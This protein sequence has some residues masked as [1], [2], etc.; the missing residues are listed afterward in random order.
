VPSNA[1]IVAVMS[2]TIDPT[3]LTSSSVTVTPSNGSAIAGT[4]TLASDGVTL[5]FVPSATL[6]SNK[7]YTVSVSGFSDAEGNTVTSFTSTFTAGSGNYGASSFKL[8]STSPANKATGIAVNSQVTFTMT[9]LIQAAS[10]NPQTVAVEICFDG[11]ACSASESVAG[12]YSVSGATITFTPLTPYPGSTVMGMEVNGL[13]D[14]AGNSAPDG[15]KYFT[16]A[17]TADTTPPTVTITPANGATNIGLN[18]Q[19]V[20]SFSESINA[21]TITSSSLAV[22]SGD[23]AVS[24]NFTISADNRTIILTPGGSAW[25]SGAVITVA[26]SNAIQDL[27]GNALVNTS[28]QFTLTTAASGTVPTVVSM[29]PG[30][31][32]TNVPANT[33]ITLFTSAAM[34]ASTIAG[35]LNVTDNGVVVSGSVQLFS[36]GQAIEFTPSSAFNPGDLIQVFLGST[37]LGANGAALSS[38]SGQFTVAGSLA[39]TAQV[40]AMNPFPNATS[41]PRNTNIQVEYNQA[42]LSS[43]VS[44]NGNSGSVT[45]FEVSSS[46]YLTP[47]CTVIGGGQVINIAPTGNLLSGSQY[48]VNVT[49]A[50]TNTSGTPVLAST[51]SFTAGT[52]VDNAAPTIV[53]Q[54]PTNNAT[55]IGTNARVAMNFNKAINPVSVTGSTIQLTGGSVTEVPSS[56]SFTPDYT[57]VM[58]VPQAPLPPS[59]A[60]TLAVNGVTSQAGINAATTSTSFTTAAQPD[61]TAP[62]VINS[63]VQNGQTNVPVNSVFSM[64]FSK[65][66]DIGSFNASNVYL[67]GGVANAIAPTTISWSSDQTTVS[68]VPT[69]PLNIGDNYSLCSS[70]MTDLD[71]NVQTSFCAS[72]TAAFTT[73]S[74]GPSVVNTSPENAQTQVP[75]NAPVQ[76]LFSEPVQPNTIG[77]ITLK[78]GGNPIAVSTSFSDA[79]QLLTLTPALPLLVNTSYTISITGVKDT[80]GNSM[81]GTVTNTF[82][83][84]GTFD[85]GAPSV[86]LTDPAADAL[87]VGTNV[88]ARVEFSKRM[89]PLSIATSSNEPYNQGSVELL[90]GDTGVPVPITVTMSSDRTTAILTPTSALLP[91]TL[92]QLSV[93]NAG[94]YYDVAGNSGSPYTSFF[95]T[96]ASTVASGTNVSSISPAN[97]QANVPLNTL[98]TVLMSGP[99]DP[100]SITNSSI[101]VT[102]SGASALAGTVSLASDGVTLTFTPASL[103]VRATTFNVSVS[104]FRDVQGNTVTTKTSTFTTNSATYGVNSFSVVSTNPANSTNNVPVN[105]PVTFTMTNLIDA[106]SV[107]AQTVQLVCSNSP[108][109]PCANATVAGTYSVTGNSV[110][111]TPLTPYPGGASMEMTLNGLMDVAGNVVNGG[112]VVAGSFSTVGT[113]DTTKPTVAITPSNGATNI[114]LNPQIVLTFSE[115]INPTT[116]GINSVAV[117]SGD[118]PLSPSITIS[119]DNRTVVLSG[120]TLPTSTKITVLANHLITDLSGN[121]LNDT[122]SQFTTAS[123]VLTSAPSVVNT[124]PANGAT[125]VATNTVIT[126]FTSA[127]M[128]VGTIPGAL[129]VSQNGV[130]V[131]G[132][133]TVAA[134]GQSI[135]FTPSSSFTAG[136]PIQV[137]L[138]STAQDTYGNNLTNFQATFTTAGSTSSSAVV[139]AVN[140]G[141][142]TS[143]VPLNTTIQVQYNQALQSG[144]VTCN[145]SSGSVTVKDS[146][147]TYLTPN[148]TLVGGGQVININPTGNLAAGTQYTVSVSASVTNTS[149]VPVSPFSYTFTAGAAVDNA[150]PVVISVTPPD[151]SIH[152]GTNAG[153]S[154]NFDRAINPVSVTGSSIQLSGGAVTAVPSSISFTPDYTRVTI[155]P[156]SPLPPNTQMAI[157]INGVTS[158]AGVPVAS[159]TTHFTTTAGPDL[160][161][162]FVIHASV[163]TNQFVGTNAAFAMQFNEP[164]DP[165]SVNPA[166]AQDVYLFDT[167]ASAAVP[168]TI[169]FSTDLTTVMLTPT[170]SLTPG[171]QMS[172]CSSAMTNLS[173]I[174]QQSFC[175]NFSVGA[176]PD[177]TGPSILQ[178]SP[179]AG[180]T[181]VGTNALIQILFNEQLDSASLAGVTL[182][183]GGSTIPT[184]TTLFDGNQG[185]QLLPLAPLASNT[186][187]TINVTGVLDITGNAQSSAPS[188]SF[189]TGSGLDLILPTVI[190][191]N[192]T[193]GATVPVTTTVQ[194]VFSEAMDPA[195]FDPNSSFTLQ[196]PSHNPVPAT[197]SFSPDY[198]TVTLTPNSALTNGV[199]YFMFASSL[200]P[201]Y[202]LAGNKCASKV[203]FFQTTP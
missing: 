188:Q 79:N 70:L 95:T 54:A 145:G 158:V 9:N 201:L 107:S 49:S 194:F 87:A 190:S 33:A 137:F 22:F 2:N 101:T 123:A 179:P 63:S 147:N 8:S 96:G 28:S 127:P 83:T 75:T 56:I 198:T 24:Y 3:T 197:I 161:S 128:N 165:G 65:P 67:S 182:K 103:L 199:S 164:I 58:I 86:L 157:A 149:S 191:T 16:T 139:Q 43:S 17:S 183:Q 119:A 19:I 13:L 72:F 84:G 166:G 15:F 143:N 66:M 94:N 80:A 34:N 177:T 203:L 196:D 98:V 31:G 110:T 38:F 12:T 93:G 50:V 181:G 76:I 37:A 77:Q 180:S 156:Q 26:L 6:V 51:F 185:I 11:S 132:T 150:A 130:A 184:I 129:Y 169:T 99:I 59:T 122:M 134:N 45:L 32:S 118:V 88:I 202:D 48:T 163:A 146:S 46:T 18:A 116:V 92:Y 171:D 23:T 57:R 112:F 117:F 154:V 131:S 21:S 189:T 89:N 111:F 1:Q 174:T 120:V 133:P 192:P 74:N 81:V 108:G 91:N 124:R 20:L 136:T 152:I 85:L 162:P 60:M 40:Q 178:V 73:N 106:A 109:L 144:S 195:S 61:F 125:N 52:T 138:N 27:S 151:S 68:L 148:C 35:A 25:T 55:N 4:L 64:Q 155:L 173:G 175:V 135:V 5:T 160:T 82:T 126:L 102:P 7:V 153:V 176:L 170:S 121:T 47:N 39:T 113:N 44:C 187:Y 159:Q 42:L 71:G 115:S 30:N 142:G 100:T 36:N 41:V 10:V 69:S 140:P 97:G 186:A 29:R 104:G 105:S 172:M 14:E 53:S 200:G 62:F 114:G 90:N 193:L 167:T 168:A 78:T 141:A